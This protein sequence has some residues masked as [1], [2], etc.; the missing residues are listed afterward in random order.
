MNPEFIVNHAHHPTF[1]SNPH[2]MKV[3]MRS[4]LSPEGWHNNSR[5]C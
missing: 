5:G 1:K 2:K 3:T 4:N